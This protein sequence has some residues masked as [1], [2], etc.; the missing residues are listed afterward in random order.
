MRRLGGSLRWVVAF[1]ALVTPISLAG[2]AEDL[3]LVGLDENQQGVEAALSSQEYLDRLTNAVSAASDSTLEALGRARLESKAAK[4]WHVH[5]V[6]V[7]V[8]AE[9]EVGVG[10]LKLKVAPRFRLA[11]TDLDDPALP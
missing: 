11:F 8:S 10:P 4:S 2:A 5:V 6:L 1:G 3:V 9:V 7:G